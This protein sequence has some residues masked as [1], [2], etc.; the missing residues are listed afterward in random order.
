MRGFNF[1]IV[2]WVCVYM[3]KF[4]IYTFFFYVLGGNLLMEF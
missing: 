3:E 1:N 2:S 4:S